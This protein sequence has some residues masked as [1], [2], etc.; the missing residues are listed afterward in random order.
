MSRQR[1]NRVLLVEDEAVMALVTEQNV[2][3][4][5]YEV[6][7]IAHSEA[8]ALELL[9]SDRPNLA[10]VDVRLAPGDGVR[11]ARA[12][13]DHGCAVVF[14]T[15]H[16]DDLERTWTDPQT[17]CLQK[18]YNAANVPRALDLLTGALTGA[19]WPDP[20]PP[21]MRLVPATAGV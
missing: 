18:P 13:L 14:A 19:P 21:G 17:L 8:R 1:A 4:A 7:G 5:G 15:A 2:I 10:V 12:L 9:V 16:C 11:V 20:L 3:A 6:V